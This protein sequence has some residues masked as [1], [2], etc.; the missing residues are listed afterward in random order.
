VPVLMDQQ[1]SGLIMW[2]GSNFFWLGVLTAVFF[3]WHA[4]EEA[5]ERAAA[6][7][8]RARDGAHAENNHERIA[9]H[10]A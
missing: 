9:R 7:A 1:I 3:A 8:A 5:E 10:P 4:R 6:A 2:V